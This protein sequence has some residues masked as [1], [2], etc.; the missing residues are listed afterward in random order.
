MDY[1]NNVLGAVALAISDR[2]N[3]TMRNQ[4]K[5][6]GESAAAIIFLGYIPGLSVEVLR[7]VLHLSHAGTVRLIDRL[8]QDEIIVRRKGEDA[9][10]VSLYLTRKGKNLRD[11]LMD[12]R[13]VVLEDS[14]KGLSKV[15]RSTLGELL[16]KVLA[17]LPESEMDKHNICRLCSVKH[18]SDECPIPGNA[19]VLEPYRK[20]KK[21]NA[22]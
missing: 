14:L 9:R 19:P 15:E 17:N 10:S 12:S 22:T 5:R 7:Q 18:C 16:S 3:A 21:D 4:S 8:Q 2:L 6:S 11:R 13:S 20:R 1:T